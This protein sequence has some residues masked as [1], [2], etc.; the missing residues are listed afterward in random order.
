MTKFV[1]LMKYKR[2]HILPIFT[3]IVTFGMYRKERMMAQHTSDFINNMVHEFQTPLSN[4]HLATNLIKKRKPG[5]KKITEYLEIIKNE[6]L[7]LEKN[8]D[9]ILKVSSP[10]NGPLNY[11][12]VDVH[13]AIQSTVLDFVPRIENAGGK[14]DLDF[15]ARHHTFKADA[16]HLKLIFGNLIDNAI[17]Y[18]DKPP[19]IVISTTNI[20]S[21]IEIKVKD[22]GIGIDKNDLNLI[23]EKYYRVSTGDIHNIKGFGLG[24]TFVKKMVEKYNGKI[25]V[26]S[27]K[28]VGTVFSISLPLEHEADKNTAG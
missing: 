17:K 13:E 12:P 18:S 22:N 8:V 5:D 21:N 27:T 24:L 16:N 11:K 28:G 15:N 25:G 19:H 26:T 20:K 9:E 3:F 7:K 4:I 10:D 23:F 14:I 6:N 2:Q 1:I